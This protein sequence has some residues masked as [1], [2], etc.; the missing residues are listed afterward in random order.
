MKTKFSISFLF[1]ILFL[2]SNT[3]SQE[4]QKTNE[5]WGSDPEQCKMNLSVYREFVKQKNYIDALPAWRKTLELCPKSTKN[6]YIDGVKIY[7]YLIKQNKDN[8][9]LRKKYVDSLMWVYDMRIKYFGNEGENIGKKGVDLYSYDKSRYNEA[10]EFCKKSY[11]ALGKNTLS[12]TMFTL[13][14][15][16]VKKFQKKEIEKSQVLED[17]TSAMGVYEYIINSAPSKKDSLQKLANATTN[18]KQKNKLLKKI[19]RIDKNVKLAKDLQSKT[20]ILFTKSGVAD[21][22][23]LEAIYKPK[24]ETHKTDTVFLK[25]SL[26][27]LY[28][29]GCT[30]SD[31][32]VK[33]AEAQYKIK[34]TETSA[35]SIAKILSKKGEYSKAVNY[36]KEA[37]KLAKDSS[38]DKAKYYFELATIL[39]TKLNQ[40]QE[41]RSYAYKALE[42]KPKWGK[43]YLLIGSLYASSSKSCGK[44]KFEQQTVFW[45]AVDMFIKAKSVDPDITEEANKLIVKYSKYF[46]DKEDAFFHGVKDGD[47][48]QIECWIN[49]K[50]KARFK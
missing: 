21:C 40:K 35:Y 25:Q 47:T 6:L 22:E 50:T 49:T 26:K 10:Y 44:N 9:E 4:Q 45:A 38:E 27:I 39:G 30:E 42:I 13:F 29:V 41:A 34:P 20:E 3:F 36:Y 18:Q 19:K 24:F 12:P 14:R 17:F 8:K 16:A 28:K 48:Y 2:V 37:I 5:K 33:I 15:I 46:P 31:I 11:Q 7:K 1:F 32:F 23:T 43:P